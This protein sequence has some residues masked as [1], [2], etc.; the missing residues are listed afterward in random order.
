[1]ARKS[2]KIDPAL[3]RDLEA[4][5]Q[6]SQINGKPP[7]EGNIET[8]AERMQIVKSQMEMRKEIAQTL[9]QTLK[10]YEQTKLALLRERSKQIDAMYEQQC[11]AMSVSLADVER[12]IISSQAIGALERRLQDALDRE[13][14]KLH[15]GIECLDAVR[16]G[17]E[18]S[19][20]EVLLCCRDYRARI[21]RLLDA[22]TIE[23]AREQHEHLEN[24]MGSKV[25]ADLVDETAVLNELKRPYRLET[26]QRFLGLWTSVREEHK[27]LAKYS[28]KAETCNRR[29]PKRP[30][31]PRATPAKIRKRYAEQYPEC[32]TLESI[33]SRTGVACTQLVAAYKKLVGKL[34]R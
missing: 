10:E 23:N 29:D 26:A 22:F 12:I 18:L 6:S 20:D 19:L 24:N 34:R 7:V 28:R 25:G 5:T 14:D 11:K 30:G 9:M 4:L 15:G 17:I 8:A 33:F 21:D 1:M 3:L 27:H 32:E 13:V 16:G 2:S 31:G